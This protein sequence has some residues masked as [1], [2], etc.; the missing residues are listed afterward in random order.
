MDVIGPIK[1]A[2]PQSYTQCWD[3]ALRMDLVR[4][5]VRH[6][7]CLCDMDLNIGRF[8]L[9]ASSPSQNI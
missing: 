8:V 1:D 7:K 2:F 9:P 5:G 6:G 4:L 3:V